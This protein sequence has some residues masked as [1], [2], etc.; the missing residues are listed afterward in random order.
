MALQYIA[1][2]SKASE[3]AADVENAMLRG[4][5]APGERLPAVRALANRLHVSTATVASA[6][7]YLRMRGLVVAGG[8]RGTLVA[9][10][11]AL[12]MRAAP[13]L[14]AG[15]RNLA[16]GSPDP[17]LLP[18]LDS[19]APRLKLRPRMYG[20]PYNDARLLELAK[21]MF[22]ADGIACGPIAIVGGALD[23][24]ERVL[25]ARLRM[26][27]RVAVEDPGY[28]LIFDLLKALGLSAVPV[29]LDRFGLCPDQLAQTLKHGVDALVLTPRAQNP[30]G[31]AL[32]RTRADELRQVIRPYPELLIIE[33]DH[34]GPVAGK[35]AFTL[36]T[37]NRSRWAVV[38]SLSK[39][40]GP[41]LRIAFLTGDELTI[42]RVEGWQRLGTGWVSNI[43]QQLAVAAWTDS[44]TTRLIGR[45]TKT[46]Q[47]RRD[48]LIRELAR[49]GIKAY[50]ESG[51]NVW[52]PVEEEAVVVR[53]LLK[54][55]WAV[56]A[57]ERFRI[58]SPAA[59][60]VS[61]GNLQRSEAQ[62]LAA[63]FAQCLFS[64]RAVYSA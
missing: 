61:I 9:P 36:S 58:R 28:H 15:V 50:G 2:G 27:D 43:L 31:A 21:R 57:G 29:G 44:R 12:V 49:R 41:D 22:T 13:P 63:D 3:I 26:G 56:A 17:A 19:V 53:G 62:R 10:Q 59:V 60:R 51:L 16:E 11:P 32:D 42:G 55:G 54:A 38:R 35:P 37:S 24:V 5:L 6:Y 45:A 14:P 25:R 46:Y 20:E 33:D 40:L 23:G 18:R 30:T 4:E 8:R 48:A 34:A 47:A 7:R 52:V 64:P 39:W 1:R